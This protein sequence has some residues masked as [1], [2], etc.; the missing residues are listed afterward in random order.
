MPKR[1]AGQL[2]AHELLAVPAAL[3]EALVG[4][5]D[6]GDMA[7]IRAI[8]ELGGG[9]RVATGR[10]HHDDILLGGGFNVDVVHADPRPCDRPQSRIAIEDFGGDLHAAAANGAVGLPHA[11]C[12]SSPFSPVRTSAVSPGAERSSPRPSWDKSSSTI[13]FGMVRSFLSAQNQPLCPLRLAMA[14]DRP[15]PRAAQFVNPQI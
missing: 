12:R 1:F 4:R 13:I 15:V 8:V 11:P 7:S 10:V 6:L 2:H 14:M 5:R 3:A 9:N